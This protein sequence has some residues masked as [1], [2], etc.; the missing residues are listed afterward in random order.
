MSVEAQAK[1]VMPEVPAQPPVD[2]EQVRIQAA[3]QE[4]NALIQA[5]LQR[6]LDL[7]GQLAVVQY[8]LKVS[9]ELN[10]AQA[11]QITSLQEQVSKAVGAAEGLAA[12][13]TEALQDTG[14]PGSP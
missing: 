7:A 13:A 8:E 5:Q 10:A 11:Q 4:M 14:F 1:P 9:R 2:L 6:G 12:V 3:V